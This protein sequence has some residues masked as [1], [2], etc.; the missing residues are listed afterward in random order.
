MMK[1]GKP[2]TV[3]CSTVFEIE[4]IHNIVPIQVI[5]SR[6]VT[7]VT[8]LGGESVLI[9]CPCI[10]FYIAPTIDIIIMLKLIMS[11]ICHRKVMHIYCK[12]KI[13]VMWCSIL[14]AI[15]NEQLDHIPSSSILLASIHR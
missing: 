11:L 6:S 14:H 12:T 5:Q 1:L 2:I 8:D 13:K 3:W 9:M 7:L 4:G 15:L 10:N